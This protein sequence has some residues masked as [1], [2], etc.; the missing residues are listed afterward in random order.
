MKSKHNTHIKYW[1]TPLVGRGSELSNHSTDVC[2]APSATSIHPYI[3]SPLVAVIDLIFHLLFCEV[4]PFPVTTLQA[5]G[6]MPDGYALLINIKMITNADYVARDYLISNVNKPACQWAY[7]IS[8]PEQF[9][10]EI[11]SMSKTLA[12]CISVQATR[13]VCCVQAFSCMSV[14]LWMQ[15]NEIHFTS[16]TMKLDCPFALCHQ[17]GSSKFSSV[18]NFESVFEPSSS[19]T[20]A[21]PWREI[22]RPPVALLVE[23]PMPDRSKGKGQTKCSPWSSGLVVGR[24]PNDPTTESFTLKPRKRP[25]PTQGWGAGKEEKNFYGMHPVVCLVVNGISRSVYTTNFNNNKT[26]Y[27]LLWQ[28]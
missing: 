27:T 19:R 6:L 21:S 7:M 23:P 22:L 28:H 26:K 24:G 18:P 20:T 2:I 4:S 5:P 3:F 17:Q 25:R 11:I 15:N 16:V 13:L 10:C 14:Q 1:Y 9:G 8:S 12:C